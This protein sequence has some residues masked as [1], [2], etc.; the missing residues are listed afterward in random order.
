MVISAMEVKLDDVARRAGLSRATV[1]LALNGSPKVNEKTRERVLAIAKE[2]KY[3]P[4]PYAR[5]LVTR[6]SRQIALVVPDIEN[7]YYASFAQNVLTRLRTTPYGLSVCVSLDSPEMER[8]IISQMIEYR[9]SALM[10]APVNCPNENP[11]YLNMLEEANIPLLFVTSQYPDSVV[12][13]ACVMYDLYGGMKLVMRELYDHGYRRIAM[14]SGSQD[15][16][17][18]DLRA[19]GYCD[20]ISEA[21]LT[22]RRIYHLNGIRYEDAQTFIR[23]N[24]NPDAD[25]L[26][27]VNDMM[28]LGAINALRERGVR[29]PE[30]IAVAGYDDVIFTTVSPVPITTVRQDI[31]RMA[32]EAVTRI[33]KLAD[34]ET[35]D[36]CTL[37]CELIRRASIK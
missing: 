7:V 3:R 10:L 6:K 30:D 17:C 35:V 29:V 31:G 36:S 33:L 26:V 2:M 11:S 27:C 28:A 15:V 32:R 4:N 19:R 8:R 5:N 9:V 16:H 13:N 24:T 21:G 34:G 20:F 14:L 22:F 12:G 25:A 37:Q 23:G 18:I 1:S